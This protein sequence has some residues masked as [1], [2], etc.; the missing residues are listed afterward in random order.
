MSSDSAAVY[1]RSRDG[2]WV[3]VWQVDND[4]RLLVSAEGSAAFSDVVRVIAPLDVT[5]RV[6]RAVPRGALLG[7]VAFTTYYMGAVLVSDSSE[8]GYW[9][10]ATV[11][12]GLIGAGAGLLYGLVVPADHTFEFSGGVSLELLPRE[13]PTQRLVLLRVSF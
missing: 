5:S 3:E 4:T 12:G 2:P 10:I 1:L 11:W 6:W 7:S 13:R 9:P 8:D